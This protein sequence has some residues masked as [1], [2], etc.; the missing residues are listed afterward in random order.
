MLQLSAS[1]LDTHHEYESKDAVSHN[2][3]SVNY[4]EESIGLPMGILV[5]CT[6][7]MY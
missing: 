1:D 6:F 5:A 3:K 2:L 7:V 4:N